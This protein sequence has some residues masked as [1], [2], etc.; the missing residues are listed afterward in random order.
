MEIALLHQTGPLLIY[1]DGDCPITPDRPPANLPQMEIALLHQTGPPAY[2]P[3]M[4][5][6]LLHQAG[7]LLIDPRCRLPYYTRH[8]LGRQT[9]EMMDPLEDFYT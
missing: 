5:I 9:P 6:A 2:Q 8:T 3:Q 4:E 1:P 7:P